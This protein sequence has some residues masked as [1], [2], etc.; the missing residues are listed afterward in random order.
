[1][2]GLNVLYVVVEVDGEIFLEVEVDLGDLFIYWVRVGVLCDFDGI[3]E[4]NFEL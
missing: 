2:C 1:M 4:L 3:C